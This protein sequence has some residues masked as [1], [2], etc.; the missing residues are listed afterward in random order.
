MRR[1]QRTRSARRQRRDAQD[2]AAAPAGRARG[3]SLGFGEGEQI[4]RCVRSGQCG[5]EQYDREQTDAQA[6]RRPPDVQAG[7][8]K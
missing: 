6:H 2:L 8:C 3:G 4:V 1:Q 5:G 7:N